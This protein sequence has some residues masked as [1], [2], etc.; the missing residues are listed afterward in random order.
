MTLRELLSQA[1][2]D[3]S[4]RLTLDVGGVVQQLR[5]MKA[6]LLT[7]YGDVDKL[8]LKDVPSPKP[9]AGEVRIKVAATS[10]NPVD[11]KIRSGEA[12][13]MFPQKLPSILGRDVSGEIVE[14][15]EGVTGFNKGDKVLAF[16]EASYCEEVAVK[17]S[18]VAKVPEGMNLQEAGV[19]P[20]VV[21]TGAQL[22]E[23]TNVQ[24]GQTILVTGAVGPVGRTAV[25]VARQR[26]AKVLAGV[27][28]KD[29]E[30]A[31]ELR[32]DGIVAIDDDAEIAAMPELDGIAN[33]VA[34]DTAKKLVS[35]VK[36]GG[37]IGSALGDVPGA[38]ERGIQVNAFH[39][40]ANA[41]QLQ[42]LAEAVAKERFRIPIAKRFTLAQAGEAQKAAEKGAG[43]KVLITI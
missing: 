22:V 13:A 20:L 41:R 5:P 34:P 32:A 10:V 42:E 11:Y 33:T 37:T 29:K 7:D 18:T 9:K 12:K 2:G 15:G 31:K 28:K 17:A 38:K 36:K 26:G 21:T 16:V 3:L 27:R 25:Y 39:A 4:G 23:H 35:K 8:Q 19:L 14:L 40:E 1:L 24:K 43:G 6:I 30:K